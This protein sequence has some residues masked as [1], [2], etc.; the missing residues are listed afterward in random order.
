[1]KRMTKWMTL[2]LTMVLLVGALPVSAAPLDAAVTYDLTD[3]AVVENLKLIGRVEANDKGIVPHTTASGIAFYS[4]CSGDI[5]LE[6]F[7]SKNLFDA[8]YFIVYV[9]GEVYNR[10]ELNHVAK[11][12]TVSKTLT[13][14]EDLEAGV[15]RIEIYRETEE[16]NAYC[17]WKSITLNG[18]LTPVPEAPMLI[19]FVGDSITTGY[20]AYPF[21][22]ADK[23][24]PVDHPSRQAGT[25][26]YAFLTAR[27][28]GMDISVTCTSGYGAQIGWNADGVNM[29]D[30]YEKTAFHHDRETDWSFE[31]PADIVVINLGTNDKSAHRTRGVKEEKVLAGM[32]NLVEIV[33]AKNPDAKIVWVT[34]MMGITFKGGLTDIMEE[35][36]GAEAG[37][38]FCV[39]PTGTSGG[40]GHPN[41]EEHQAGADTLI[42]FLKENVLDADYEAGYVT[43]EKAEELLN[44]GLSEFD[45][46][47]L[48]AEIAAAKAD[49]VEVSGTLKTTY[50]E[51]E[52]KAGG[53][54]PWLIVLAAVGGVAVIGLLVFAVCYKPK[55][56]EA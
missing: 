7:G 26:S 8:Q 53:D 52:A 28:L 39:L 21:S 35:L 38:Y 56:K 20:G 30:M 24:D 15:H 47:V 19:E 45:S 40:A 14:A 25:K 10:V 2:L 22:Y 31:R 3:A 18:T 44:K 29:Q 36:G 41:E 23:N 37:Y 55:K 32:K 12:R 33:R 16:I 9:D 4:D 49:G 5:E 51:L 54:F 50:D 46:G 11:N 48:K 34:G 13:I 6:V 42:Q 27:A 43:A 17:E 1:M